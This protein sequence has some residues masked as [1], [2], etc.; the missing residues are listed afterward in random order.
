MP[1]NS[2]INRYAVSEM[3]IDSVSPLFNLEWKNRTFK[4]T[5]CVTSRLALSYVRFPIDLALLREYSGARFWRASRSSTL[6]VVSLLDSPGLTD[7]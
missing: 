3:G 6:R 2:W 7:I 5:S 4:P 1:P